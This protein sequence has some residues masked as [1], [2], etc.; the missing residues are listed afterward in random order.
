MFFFMLSPLILRLLRFT[1]ARVRDE[2]FN[3]YQ[4]FTFIFAI[5]GTFYDDSAPRTTRP[6]A[7]TFGFSVVFIVGQPQE[8]HAEHNRDGDKQR[9]GDDVPESH[10][11]SPVS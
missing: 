5:A 7:H 11:V 3:R 10:S 1:T 2:L 4:V 9:S 6:K 8:H